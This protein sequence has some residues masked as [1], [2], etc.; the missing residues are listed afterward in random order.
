MSEL[1]GKGFKE[2]GEHAVAGDVGEGGEFEG[3]VAAGELEGAGIG[4]VAAKGVEH[5]AREMGEHGGV[6]LA[7]DHEGGTAGA[8]AAFD[9]GH[10]TDGGP[11]FAEF[12]DGDVVAK[13]F[14]DVIG[15]HALADDIGVVGGDVEETA[16]A[17]AFVVNKSDVAD[18]GADAGAEDAELGVALLFEPVEASSAILD[19]L[20]VGLQGQADIGAAD[21]VGALVAF[22]H[23][24]VVIGHAQLEDGDA[25]ALN[26]A[27]KAVLAMPFGVP[28][29]EEEDG[30]ACSRPL[31]ARAS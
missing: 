8:H 14:P 31:A 5:L 2:K 3:V 1:L 18:R 29:G 4:A 27:A 17:D 19:S 13:A 10:G 9:V 30:G 24:A 20:A 7:V 23:A 6:V 28:V 25:E 16:G 11:V 21:L 26:P 15:G 22:G 12:V